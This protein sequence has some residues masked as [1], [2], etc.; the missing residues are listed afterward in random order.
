MCG[1]LKGVLN[2]SGFTCQVSY[3]FKTD[4]RGVSYYPHTV[5]ILSFEDARDL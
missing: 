5:F 1:I 3:Q 2:A 4:E